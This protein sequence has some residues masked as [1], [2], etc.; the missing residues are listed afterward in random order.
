MFF[1]ISILCNWP[2]FSKLGGL[3]WQSTMWKLHCTHGYKCFFGHIM[4]VIVL[5]ECFS[6]H[7]IHV[8]LHLNNASL[9]IMSFLNVT[10]H[11]CKPNNVYIQN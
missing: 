1:L 5:V 9:I 4:M 6:Y 2:L 7:E 3:K 10:F 11:G 8:S